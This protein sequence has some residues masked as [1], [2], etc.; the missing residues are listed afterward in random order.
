MKI[1]FPICSLLLW[2]LT[3]NASTVELTSGMVVRSSVSFTAK[4]YYINAP[5]ESGV[6]VLIIEG[7]NIVVDFNGAILQGSNDIGR[8]D[9]MYGLAICIKKGSENIL[10]KNANI[11][12]YKIGIL[13]DS[14]RNLTIDQSDLS[15]NWRQHLQSNRLRED[16]SDW[17]SYHNNENDEWLRY[18]AAIYLKN[19]NKATVT[20]TT[21]MDGQCALMMTKCDNAVIRDNIFSFNSGI[22]I[23]LYRSSN[24]TIYHNRLDYN[25]RGF[26]AGK[27]HR[28]QDSA[29]L[30][31]FEQCNN[32]IIAFNTATHSGD[33]FFLW[34]GQSTLDTGLGGCNDNLVY[35]NDFSCAPANGV[36]VTFSRNLIMKN[37]IMDCDY[38]I[39]GG[40]S[41]E[42]D[43][44][45]NTFANNRIGIAIEHG[46]D[47][48]IALNRFTKDQT[49]IKLWS[50]EKQ[51]V[52][53]IYSQKK[54]TSSRNYWI[55]ANGF[56]MNPVAFDIMGTDTVVFSGNTRLDVDQHFVFG[57][58]INNID[59]S[60]ED[61][62]LDMDYQP[63]ERIRKLGI[64]ERPAQILPE[65]KNEMRITEWGP[66][67]F[68]YPLIWLKNIDSNGI[69]QFE[70]LGPAGHWTIEHIDGFQLLEKGEGNFPSYLTAKA[71]PGISDRTIRLNFTGPSFPDKFGNRQDSSVTRVFAYREFDPQT[72]W[73]VN[74][75]NWDAEH[76][77]GKDYAKFTE[78]LNGVPFHSAITDKVDFTWWGAV[79]K[80]LPADSF[81]TVAVTKIQLKENNYYIGITAD[82][83]AKL[84]IDGKEVINAWDTAYTKPDE[85]TH[86]HQLIRLSSGEHEFRIIQA[87]RTGLS[88]LQFYLYPEE[89]TKIVQ[90]RGGM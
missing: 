4:K 59:T 29:A 78:V 11:H 16:I 6:P 34:A 24:N 5:K 28:G 63:D 19:C 25:V 49:A 33:G 61:E 89:K 69:Y 3:L 62:V 47:I 88:A 21:V 60:R 27:Y 70:I 83:Y 86:H 64:S 22:G 52:D 35:G 45:D 85:N 43:I 58:D 37:I 53:W 77:P 38:G 41:Y 57:D 72:K 87:D 68:Q 31:L 44:T 54:N 30:L 10:I 8:P 36:E 65:G 18:G 51:P 81:A 46:Q 75:Y 79:D 2:A 9:D 48:N 23:G 82:D 56:T 74:W 84:Y 13:A 12:G 40:Y 26:S 73:S 50:G 67:D 90:P 76:D 80:G 1:V 55:A 17:M 7:K 14:V 20:H 42:S 39:W 66:Y 32:N 15:Y 71:D